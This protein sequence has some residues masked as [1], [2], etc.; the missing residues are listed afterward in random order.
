M[1]TTLEAMKSDLE[2]AM[3]E[4]RSED[5]EVARSAKV[6]LGA[7]RGAM[8]AISEAETKGKSRVEL[9]DADVRN[10]LRKSVKAMRETAEVYR[11][12]GAEEKAF[13]EEAEADVLDGYLPQQASEAETREAVVAF[14]EEQGLAGTGMRSM[15]VV[16]KHFGQDERFDKAL[17]ARFAKE[18]V[19]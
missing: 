3:R 8:A 16:V 17:V 18:L 11:G 13:A 15:G 4:Q 14:V 2:F 5:A 12:A 1:A 10:L 9:S 7:I 19:A 6:R